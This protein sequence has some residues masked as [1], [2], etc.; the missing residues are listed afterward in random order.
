MWPVA[1]LLCFLHSFFLITT[2]LQPNN[3]L[4]ERF[5]V[6]FFFFFQSGFLRMIV[7]LCR[8]AMIGPSN[9]GTRTVESAFILSLNMLGEHFKPEWWIR[10]TLIGTILMN[11]EEAGCSLFFFYCFCVI[12]LIWMLVCVC[13]DYRKIRWLLFL[14]SELFYQFCVV[15][16]LNSVIICYS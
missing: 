7:W 12:L 9:C 4:L 8:A 10:V 2:Q 11:A 6:S 13:N 3:F 16:S 5:C 15:H 14:H 1:F